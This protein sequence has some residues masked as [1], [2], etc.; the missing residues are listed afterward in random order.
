MTYNGLD[1]KNMNT[2]KGTM[3][4]QQFFDYIVENFNLDGTAQRLVNNALLYAES[5][6]ERRADRIICIT[7]LL[8][9]I[10]LTAEEINMIM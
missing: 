4:R 5:R 9:D 7:D 3:N 6:Y 2:E 8:D 1:I 10:G